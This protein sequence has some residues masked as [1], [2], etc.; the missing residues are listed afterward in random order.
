[1]KRNLLCLISVVLIISSSIFASETAEKKNQLKKKALALTTSGGVSLGSY[2]GGLL[3][4]SNQIIK[5]AQSHELKL[6][7][8]ASAGGINSLLSIIDQCSLENSGPQDNIFWKSWIPLNIDTLYDPKKVGKYN[9]FSRDQVELILDLMEEHWRRGFKKDCDV[10]LSVSVTRANKYDLPI[11]ERLSVPR[12]AETFMVR[13]EGRGED[14]APKVSNYLFPDEKRIRL[15]LPFRHGH[16]SETK[17]NFGIIRKLL[18]ATAAFPLAFSPVPISY[19]IKKPLEKG[20]DCTKENS[21]T[22]K[23]LDG[24]VFD[25]GPIRTAFNLAANG[26]EYRKNDW[27]WRKKK[28][29]REGLPDDIQFAF[30]DTNLKEYPTLKDEY[31]TQVEGIFQFF[32]RFLNQ[33]ISSA[34][35]KELASL[36]EEYPRYSSILATTKNYLPLASEPLLAFL[37]FFEESFRRFDFYVGMFDAYQHMIPFDSRGIVKEFMASHKRKAQWAPLLCIISKFEETQKGIGHCEDVDDPNFLTLLQASFDRLAY[38][39]SLSSDTKNEGD[40][41]SCKVI[42]KTQRTVLSEIEYKNDFQYFMEILE[43]RKFQF[44]DLDEAKENPMFATIQIQKKLSDMNSKLAEKQ[45]SGQGFALDTIFK[46]AL[47]YIKY[48]PSPAT[49]YISVGSGLE[50]GFSRALKAGPGLGSRIRL[51]GSFLYQGADTLLGEARPISAFTP[52]LGLEYESLYL[53]DEFT[54][55]QFGFK[56][57]HLFST[58]DDL[59]SDACDPD[60]SQ[61]LSYGCSQWV[62]GPTLSM[63][64]LERLK[65]HLFGQIYPWKRA[66]SNRFQLMFFFGYQFLEFF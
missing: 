57:G 27:N 24:G 20:G 53:S 43:K 38:Y 51:H 49:A 33:F 32:Y 17:D 56:G 31:S 22:D 18:S 66:G 25:N 3:Y 5:L 40:F 47:N 10:V 42:E 41:R 26:L 36:I 30:I 2:Q 4:F 44:H 39:C 11:V 35:S 64:I 14:K 55:Y 45:P 52:M 16:S 15:L 23:F 58:G 50:V 21:R 9:L 6:V 48:T 60:Q 46:P 59:G 1:M 62:I 7:T 13:I 19:C 61:S 8:G 34:R 65:F 63:T 54:Q 29:E 12:L 28:K 37:G